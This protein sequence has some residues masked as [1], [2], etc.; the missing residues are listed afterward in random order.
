[1]TSVSDAENQDRAQRI[2]LW[3]QLM[4]ACGAL[5]RAGLER[6]AQGDQSRVREA[7]QQWYNR[8][9]LDH[10]ATIRHVAARLQKA[11]SDAS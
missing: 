2:E 8:T 10:D 5:L 7:Y 4:A 11:C 3:L 1:M 6:E 9:R